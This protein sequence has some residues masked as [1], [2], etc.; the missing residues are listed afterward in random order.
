MG[1][2]KVRIC[3]SEYIKNVKNTT[4]KNKENDNIELK[5]NLR[6]LLQNIH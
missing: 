1:V 3:M 2:T 4:W 6:S 5:V